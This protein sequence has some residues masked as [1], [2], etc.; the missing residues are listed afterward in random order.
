MY[1][2]SGDKKGIL[3]NIVVFIVEIWKNRK[4]NVEK[5]G[6]SHTFMTKKTGQ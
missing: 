6:L 5:G 3:L 4:K 2:L 1:E